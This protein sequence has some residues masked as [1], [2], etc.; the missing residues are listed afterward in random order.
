MCVSKK[1][2]ATVYRQRLA[3]SHR[4]LSVMEVFAQFERDLCR[5]PAARGNRTGK[6]A[7]GLR[8]AEAS[9]FYR[10]R[11]RIV[12]TRSSRKSKTKLAGELSIS[13][14]TLSRRI[15]KTLLRCSDSQ[16]DVWQA[17]RCR[18]IG[19]HEDLLFVTILLSD[20]PARKSAVF[21]GEYLPPLLGF[22]GKRSAQFV[23]A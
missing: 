12:Q 17:L 1:G 10:F 11:P 16:A 9:A 5:G 6:A 20:N 8:W 15:E 14:P 4:L 13:R 18:G 2:D 21:L 3:R 23:E 19:R 7:T 22:P